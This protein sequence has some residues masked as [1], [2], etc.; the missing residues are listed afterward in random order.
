MAILYPL[1]IE[2]EG[3]ATKKGLWKLFG[4]QFLFVNPE[5]MTINRTARIGD[6]RTMGGTVFQPWPNAP[7]ELTFSGVLYGLRSLY[8]IQV[9]SDAISGSPDLKDVNLIYKWKKYPGL[10]RNLTIE[11][12]ANKPRQFPYTVSF[13][14]RSALELHRVLL[15]QLT[16]AGVERDFVRA[17]LSGATQAFK[18]GAINSLI[19]VG[20]LASGIATGGAASNALWRAATL[21]AFAAVFNIGRGKGWQKYQ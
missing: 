8:D 21:T 12:D 17:Q 18:N 20:T 9:L 11:A 1:G 3:G 19:N 2:S 5:K 16:G 13:V 4:G 14:S 10:L 15:G 7:D 6:A